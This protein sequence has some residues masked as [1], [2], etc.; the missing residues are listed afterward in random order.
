MDKFLYRLIAIL[1][2]S[3]SIASAA[4]A[5]STAWPDSPGTVLITGSDRGIGY[6]LVKQYAARNWLVLATC[7]SPGKAEALARLAER[8]PDVIVEEL[9][10]TDID[11]IEAQAAKHADASIDVL[12]NNAGIFGDITS[13]SL[14]K[15]DYSTFVEVMAVNAFGPLKV[16]QAFVDNVAASR[17]KKIVTI[18]SGLA[19]MG[20]TSNVKQGYYC[21]RASKASVNIISRTLAADLRYREILVGLFNPGVVDTGFV[22][23][24]YDGPK[25]T[26]GK[27]AD[28]LVEFI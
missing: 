19:S 26:A 8:Y 11:E 15:L 25:L 14:E 27:A 9:D 12:I 21:Y 2:L 16:S 6:E 24:N 4:R 17:Q 18:T 5:Q 3:M 1:V 22:G 13:Q 10:V 23:T 20:L 7:R 28:A